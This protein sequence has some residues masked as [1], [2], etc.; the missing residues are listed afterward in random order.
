MK[1]LYVFYF[2][3][4]EQNFVCEKGVSALL[5]RCTTSKHTVGLAFEAIVKSI[6]NIDNTIHLLRLDC[7]DFG[8]PQR[9]KL[10]ATLTFELG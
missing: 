2:F 3:P 6:A 9:T 10:Q 5:S 8:C 7:L 4:S 1:V